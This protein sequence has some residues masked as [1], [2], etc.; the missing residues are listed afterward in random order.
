MAQSL[1]E[2]EIKLLRQHQ[3]WGISIDGPRWLIDDIEAAMLEGDNVFNLASTSII[4]G[5]SQQEKAHIFLLMGPRIWTIENGESGALENG[6][7]TDD[8]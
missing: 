5:N 3:R 1:A 2:I 4:G 8:S 6:T 7:T